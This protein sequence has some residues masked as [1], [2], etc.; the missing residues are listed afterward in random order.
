MSETHRYSI[1]PLRV[2]PVVLLLCLLSGAAALHAGGQADG[3]PRVTNWAPGKSRICSAERAYGSGRSSAQW[4]RRRGEGGRGYAADDAASRVQDVRVESLMVPR[5]VRGSIE[6][7]VVLN[8]RGNR[9]AGSMR[10]PSAAAW[11]RPPQGC[12]ESF[13]KSSPWMSSTK[14][15]TVSV[16]GSCSSTGRWIQPSSTRLPDTGARSVSVPEA[17]SK[18]LNSVPWQSVRSATLHCDEMLPNWPANHRQAGCPPIPP[19]AAAPPTADAERHDDIGKVPAGSHAA[20]VPDTPRRTVGQCPRELRGSELPNEIVVVGG[21]LDS[22]DVGEGAHDDG[23][24]CVQA[25]EALRLLKELGVRPKRTIRAVMFMNE[26]NGSRGGKAYAAAAARSRERHRAA[27][28]ADRGGFTPRGYS[29]QG[30]SATLEH[31]RAWRPLFALLGAD[32]F[33]AGHS[34]V[35]VSPLM[36]HGAVGF[37]LL[38]DFHRYFD[39]HHSA[40]DILANVHPRELELGAIAN[41][42]LCYLIAEEGLEIWE[43]QRRI[44]F[45]HG[46]HRNRCC[47]CGIF[48]SFRSLPFGR[49]LGDPLPRFSSVP[50]CTRSRGCSAGSPFCFRTVPAARPSGDGPHGV[51]A[52][53][54]ASA[55]RADR[56]SPH[57]I[58][59]FCLAAQATNV[60]PR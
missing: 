55:P 30:D 58:R 14:R 33:I 5:W 20:C 42:L 43:R 49:E 10:V 36:E 57:R 1:R 16:A 41:A 47:T 2:D 22:W 4:L 59:C 11:R 27:I 37:G 15:V 54:P 23:A 17:P 18:P 21:H 32:T 25:I 3:R 51:P 31:V 60:L 29:V 50:C 45:D 44:G 12:P 35:D 53:L 24:G 56:R 13:W 39:Y 38:V 52:T 8:G 40:N 9:C 28:E 26:E 19:M 34:G 6:E 48:Y 7:A 46:R